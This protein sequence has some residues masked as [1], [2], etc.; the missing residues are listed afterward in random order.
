MFK[1][2]EEL[3]EIENGEWRIENEK[4]RTMNAELRIA[5]GEP[6]LSA[7]KLRTMPIGRQ[8]ERGEELPP[9]EIQTEYLN[10]LRTLT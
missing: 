8:V 4:W 9:I 6:C 5:N 1:A 3:I 10:V 2:I 7:G